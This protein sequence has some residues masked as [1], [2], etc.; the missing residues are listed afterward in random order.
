MSF[1]LLFKSKWTLFKKKIST[2]AMN[3]GSKE[4]ISA[5]VYKNIT[6]N[7]HNKI[8][9]NWANS[10]ANLKTFRVTH[11]EEHIAESRRF[12]IW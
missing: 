10:I 7:K 5:L 11:V 8:V 3:S 4:W 6:L 2:N 12:S 9:L 1:M